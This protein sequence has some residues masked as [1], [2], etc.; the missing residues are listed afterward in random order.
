MDFSSL[1]LMERDPKTK[2]FLREI[3]SY[4]VDEGSEYVTRFFMEGDIISLYFDTH[5]DVEE[6]EYTALF[7]VFNKDAFKKKGYDIEEYD[8]EYN[9]TWVVKFN[10]DKEYDVM[11][12]KVHDICFLIKEEIK[13]AFNNIEG[14]KEYY[15]NL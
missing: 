9:P 11:E 7:D 3:G 12:Q 8:D 15:E 10:F 1:V 5:K 14:K 4:K 6:W 2:L 13:N